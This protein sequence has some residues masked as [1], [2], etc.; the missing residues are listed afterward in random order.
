MCKLGDIIVVKEFKNE[1]GITIPK[2]SFIV[3]DDNKDSIKGLNYDF[4]TNMMG[5]FH[6]EEHKKKKLKYKQNLY[7]PKGQ[8][9]GKNLNLKDG[10]IKANNLYLFKKDK[11]RYRKIGHLNNSIT[12]ELLNIIQIL[13][14]ENKARLIT[15]NL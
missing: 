13:Q 15:T 4:V 14:K 3:I 10:F 2:H 12:N 9:I 11:I 7:I 6:N 1:N 5:S 8:I